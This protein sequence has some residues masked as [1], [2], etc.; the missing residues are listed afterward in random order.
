MVS[1]CGGGVF[2]MHVSVLCT[3][4]FT[5][6]LV[7]RTLCIRRMFINLNNAVVVLFF[8]RNVGLQ[9]LRNNLSTTRVD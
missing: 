3:V 1:H 7:A 2:L 9:F 6:W 4:K 8:K 5:T